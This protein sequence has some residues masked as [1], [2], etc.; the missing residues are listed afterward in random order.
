[1]TLD[2]N[3]NPVDADEDLL[4]LYAEMTVKYAEECFRLATQVEDLE[5]HATALQDILDSELLVP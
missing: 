2:G 1:M 5:T 3:G 4:A